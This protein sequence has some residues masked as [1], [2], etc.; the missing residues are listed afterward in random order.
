MADSVEDHAVAEALAEADLVVE[1]SADLI[2]MA[3]VDI[4]EALA[5]RILAVGIVVLMMDTEVAVAL[6]VCSEFCCFLSY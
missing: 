1:A 6:A 2:I 5:D 4:G 3:R